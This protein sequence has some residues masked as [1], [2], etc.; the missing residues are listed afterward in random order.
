MF[1]ESSCNH[2][3]NNQI[4][5]LK[6]FAGECSQSTSL[7]DAA[8]RISIRLRNSRNAAQTGRYQY[9]T[10]SW[11][12]ALWVSKGRGV[13]ISPGLVLVLDKTRAVDSATAWT[14]G[15]RGGGTV[16]CVERHGD[17]RVRQEGV[18]V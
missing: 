13:P 8:L 17:M 10:F 9:L 7:R 6:D 15:E 1:L 16:G 14:I 12:Y 2:R 3:I 4:H 18:N 11:H 5:G